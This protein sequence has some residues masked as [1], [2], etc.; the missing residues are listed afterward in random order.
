VRVCGN[1]ADLTLGAGFAFDFG[2]GL[3][4][5]IGRKKGRTKGG[6]SKEGKRKQRGNVGGGWGVGRGERERGREKGVPSSFVAPVNPVFW[7]SLCASG[8]A[9]IRESLPNQKIYGMES[10]SP[11]PCNIR[12][13][14]IRRLARSGLK[15]QGFPHCLQQRAGAENPR[16]RRA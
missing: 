6:G 11:F 9:L 15:I 4:C 5:R 3:V 16:A 1:T 8:G 14:S 2:S 13:R 12:T 7:W 10:S